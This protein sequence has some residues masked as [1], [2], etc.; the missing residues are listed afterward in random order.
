MDNKNSIT[1]KDLPVEQRPYEKCALYGEEKLTDAELLAVIIRSGSVNEQSTGLANRILCHNDGAGLMNLHTM[2]VSELKQFKGIGD[3]KA[4]QLK[5]ISELVKRMSRA[6]RTYGE[7]FTSPEIVA[8]Y[9]MESMR[10]LETETLKMALL[11]SKSRLMKDIVISSG[12]VNSSVA[13]SREI[14]YMAL[15]HGAVKIILLHNHPSGDP[16][17]SKEDIFVTSKLKDAGDIIGI[18]LTDHII[19]GDNCYYSLREAGYV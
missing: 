16:V 7:S 10:N 1:V 19:I 17:P 4:V 6:K 11:D 2:S 9:Y 15:K 14:Y 8:A 13:S 18:P 12:T 3:V 5:C